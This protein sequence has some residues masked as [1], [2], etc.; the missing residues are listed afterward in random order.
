MTKIFAI[1]FFITCLLSGI[2]AQ[3]IKLESPNKAISAI[4]EVDDNGQLNYSITIKGKSVVLK[5]PIGISV[6]NIDLGANVKISNPSAGIQKV[7]ET[8]I[9]T[10]VHSKA[11]N[12]YN[13]IIIPVIN[14]N[15]K[16]SWTLEVR[17]FDD[18]VAYRYHVDGTGIRKISGE[19]SAWQLPVGCTVW[20]Q[21]NTSREYES[22]FYVVNPDT[23]KSSLKFMTTATFKLPGKL[24]YVK[25]TEANLINYSDMALETSGGGRYKS[26]FHNSRSGWQNTGNIESPWRVVIIADNL[27]ALVNTDVL[28]N[29]CP[30]PSQKL[31]NASWIKPGRSTWHWMVTGTPKFEDQKKWINWTKQTEF[32][33]YIIDE[34]WGKWSKKG[35]DHWAFMKEVV[36]YATTQNVKIWAWTNSNELFTHKQRVDY[37]SKA[38]S[39]GIVGLKID[40]MKP[41]DPIWVNWYDDC[42]RDADQNE[43]M[44]DF[45]GCVKPTGRER[46]WPNEL[47]R[48]AVRGRE[49]EKQYSLH[50]ISLLFTRFVQG[51]AD[52]TPVDFRTEKLCGSTWT[53]ELAMSVAFTSPLLCFSGRPEDYINSD[54]AEFLKILP[55]TWDETIVLPGSEIGTLGAIARRKGN[56]WFIGVLNNLIPKDYT[57]DLKFIGPGIFTI[58][59]FEDTPEKND[60]WKHSIVQIIA[61]DKVK[62]KLLADG[63]FVARI[64]VK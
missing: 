13:E 52:Y 59:K 46:T 9:T 5:S 53:H 39:I 31:Q 23:I 45:H 7:N 51:S 40:F 33:Y 24:G 47:T 26:F 34:G 28:K 15:S 19:A 38:K 62:I 29:L 3:H 4:F 58:E 43:L 37:F 30:L 61:K 14:T 55:T 32:E 49:S 11:I 57:I 16:T 35:K 22:P 2:Y 21:D 10:G 18:A 50:D 56:E 63:G 41:A 44:I 60:S 64:K 20:L 8:Y 27:N 12:R 48:E 6:D 36:D 25:I 42:L 1:F 17:V 54:A